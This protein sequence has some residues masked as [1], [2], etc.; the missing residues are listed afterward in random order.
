MEDENITIDEPA[1]EIPQTPPMP[2]K[3]QIEPKAKLWMGFI[4]LSTLKRSQELTSDTVELDPE[5]GW[6][7]VFGHG[8][9]KVHLGDEVLDFSEERKVRMLYEDGI[10]REIT[11]DEFKSRNRGDN[12]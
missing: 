1:V 9:Y 2:S 10:L 12:W 7:L 8:Y 5:K 4:D 11:T 6:L 3:F